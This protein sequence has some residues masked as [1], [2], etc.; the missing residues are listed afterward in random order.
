MQSAV[1]ASLAKSYAESRRKEEALESLQRAHE[2]FSDSSAGR[3]DLGTDYNIAHLLMDDGLVHYHLKQYAEASA[4]FAQAVNPET[5]LPT[6]PIPS[7]RTRVQIV[8]HQA[9]VALK[10]PQKDREHIIH[11]WTAGIQGA[12]AL[13][14]EQR[15][16]EAMTAYHMMQAL[17]PDEPVIEDLEDLTQ[18]W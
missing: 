2:A 15:F 3:L 18:H 5:L 7:E 12:K 1:Y 17:W 14:S 16:N 6:I 13:R 11:I 4:A 9:L 10:Q 8:N